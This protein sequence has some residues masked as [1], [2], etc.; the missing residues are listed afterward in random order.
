M[1]PSPVL[2]GGVEAK[3]GLAKSGSDSPAKTGLGK[4]GYCLYAH[5]RT[6][7]EWGVNYGKSDNAVRADR[8]KPDLAM[9]GNPKSG[10]G[11]WRMGKIR[12]C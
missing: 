11:R 7:L 4:S 12:T 3:T 10:F 2:A 8:L 1:G 5:A 9:A 6:G